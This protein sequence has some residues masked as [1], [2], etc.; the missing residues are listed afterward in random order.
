MFSVALLYSNSL[1]GSKLGCQMDRKNGL[2]GPFCIERY[3]N[4]SKMKYC[5]FSVCRWMHTK[6]T[7]DKQTQQHPLSADALANQT[8][9]WILHDASIGF[10]IY[11]TNNSSW[12]L[13]FLFLQYVFQWLSSLGS[14]FMSSMLCRGGVL[15]PRSLRSRS[16]VGP[17][18]VTPIDHLKYK[19]P[20]R[21]Q[22]GS[23]IYSDPK[24]LGGN[25]PDTI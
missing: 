11:L 20:S 23:M 7:V 25:R 8:C 4:S 12:E 9:I 22:H 15:W 18:V 10:M 21:T 24:N 1:Y 17:D 14:S 6:G 19:K 2:V 16:H 3:R 13:S 5:S